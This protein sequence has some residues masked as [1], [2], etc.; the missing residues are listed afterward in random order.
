MNKI[1]ILPLQENDLDEI[2]VAFKKIGWEKPRDIYENY[3]T[4]QANE[5]INCETRTIPHIP[6][7][8]RKF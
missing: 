7:A 3:L 8:I 5:K 4:E 2:V 6:M 1:N